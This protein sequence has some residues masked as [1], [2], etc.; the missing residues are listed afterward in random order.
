MTTAKPSILDSRHEQIFP[1]LD[2][3]EIQ[4]LLRFGEVCCLAAGEA[5]AEAGKVGR[6]LIVILA[7]EVD[8]TRRDQLGN[9]DLIVGRC[10]SPRRKSASASCVR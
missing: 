9:R 5:L 6:G 3:V 10:S 8:I 2:E 7:G 4:R 1:K